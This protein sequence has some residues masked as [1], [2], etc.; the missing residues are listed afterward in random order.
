MF[1]WRAVHLVLAVYGFLTAISAFVAVYA[2]F[3][4]PSDPRNSIFLGLSLQRL[5]MPGGIFLIGIIL[6][7]LSVNA[8]RDRPW[9]DGI[10]LLLFGQERLAKGIR[11]GA[12]L[13]L[14]AGLTVS[15]MP[16]YRFGEYQD[17]FIRISPIV[18]WMTF[19][20]LLTFVT[21]WIQKYGLH[22]RLFLSI[23]HT[24]KTALTIALISAITFALI[25]VFVA[26]TGMG[27]TVGDGYW[28][29]VGVP[30]LPLQVIFAFAIGMGVFFLERS[31]VSARLPARVDLLVFFLLWGITAFFWAR[32]P[33]RSSFFAP[34]PLSP[35]NTYHPYSDA[36][37]FDLG[38]QFALIGQG[39]NNG[40]FFDRALYMAF[41]AFLHSL[42]GQ[43]YVQVVTLQTA[44]FAVLP[45]IMYFL[46]KEIHSRSFGIT[47]AVLTL[48]RGINGLAA[49]SMINLANQ[50]Q[51]LTDFPMLIFA[52]WFALVSVK[53]LKLPG[54]NYTYA[55]WAGGVAGLAVMLRTNA[56]FLVL[57]AALLAAIVYWR[58]KVHGLV[59]GFLLV[60][61][62]F[63]STFAWGFYNDGSIFDVYL[64]R[65][66][67]VIEARYPQPAFPE[68]QGNGSS[69]VDLAYRNQRT[70]KPYTPHSASASQSRLAAQDQPVS[71]PQPSVNT[72]GE[73]D[74]IK[75]IPVFVT[76]HFLHNIVT[77]AL[78][79]PTSPDL[80]N[81]RYTLKADDSIWKSDWSGDLA[82][83]T[84]IFLAINLLLVSLGMGVSWNSGGL[85]GLVPLG[86]FIFYDLSNAFARTSGGRYVVPI[87]WVVLFYFALGLFQ[88]V[89]WGMGLSGFSPGDDV[90]NSSTVPNGDGAVWTWEPIKKAPLIILVFLLIGTSL[91]A[92]SQI[93]PRRYV[94][95]TRNEMIT[96][97]DQ[98]GYLQKMGFDKDALTALSRQSSAFK[99]INGRALY[100]RS[101]WENE[102][103]P[104][105]RNPYSVM[106]FPRIAFMVVGPHGASA[107]ILP[108]EDIPY[109]PNA[110][111][112][113][114]LGCQ[115]DDY[116]DALAV[117]V[118]DDQQVVYVRQ[119]SSPL[120]C[121]L[122]QPVCNENHVCQ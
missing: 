113:Y 91:P 49:G 61:T 87:D 18:D 24:Q 69:S 121:P 58:Q 32:E 106:G 22:W 38:S 98:E 67:L 11:W 16:L 25:W 74:E 26:K 109:F 64:Y 52:A 81:L 88:V 75:P 107:V 117:L 9:S 122:P 30:V 66:L 15:F 118:L 97:L 57:L 105:K 116:I 43:D 31:S 12:A 44:I 5:I 80:H 40:V 119:P 62:M 13:V 4:I 94:A 47:F 37:S 27:L 111:D 86:T 102:G 70:S 68:S 1:R 84:V 28:Y 59:V 65:I 95:Q 29:E 83:G 3:L 50:K 36:S 10:W 14:L 17:Y 63:A 110:A 99:I 104:K 35:G 92:L 7:G 33:L 42:V 100:P 19:V 114:V 21:A 20:S 51:M 45:A 72:T 60:I 23:L 77:S 89:Q 85:A 71:L 79:L 108:Q 101:F 90:K 48:L 41:L 46:G 56:L 82:L 103:I 93:Y 73:D 76:L 78:I 6:T 34:G 53:W 96:L 39:I 55:L 112:V 54:K 8:L 120:E 2:L 115:K